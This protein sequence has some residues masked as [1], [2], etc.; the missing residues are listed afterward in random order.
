M[1]IASNLSHLNLGRV[2]I[3]WT[4][5]EEILFDQDLQTRAETC[6]S[7][8][9]TCLLGVNRLKLELLQKDLLDRKDKKDYHVVESILKGN[10]LLKSNWRTELSRNF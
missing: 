2:N 10:Y 5:G 1:D 9:Q 3:G 6:F 4:V 8:T 7:E